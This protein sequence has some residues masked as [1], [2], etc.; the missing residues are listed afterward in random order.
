MAL[1]AY[2]HFASIYRTSPV[3]LA[4][5]AFLTTGKDAEEAENLNHLLQEIA[6]KAVTEHPQS[7]VKGK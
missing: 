2:C 1:V 7:G 3:G 5:P 6:W 4:A